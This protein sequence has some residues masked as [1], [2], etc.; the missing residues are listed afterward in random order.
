MTV[1]NISKILE[2]ILVSFCLQNGSVLATVVN[3]A[4]ILLCMYG[5]GY[6]NQINSAIKSVLNLSI[7]RVGTIAIIKA[8]FG[9]R[10]SLDCVD[11]IICYYQE[12]K[13]FLRDAGMY[14]ASYGLHVLG[15]VIFLV[16][17]RLS[18]FVALKYRLTSKV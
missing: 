14:D 10:S 8:V 1:R 18:A 5:I 9:D 11:E 7:L 4:E 13:H 12:P 6:G 3:A 16:V 17:F 15:L 2:V